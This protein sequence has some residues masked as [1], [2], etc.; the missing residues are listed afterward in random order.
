MFYHLHF[1]E[2]NCPYEVRF[3]HDI[4]VRSDAELD[5]SVLCGEIS[6]YKEQM[7]DWTFGLTDEQIEAGEINPLAEK[8]DDF[9][10]DEK[11]D[12]ALKLVI[13]KHPELAIEVVETKSFYFEIN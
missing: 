6:K 1:D 3:T 9:G 13:E 12:E 2:T 8:Y 4:L 5:Y 7:D 10:W 11:I